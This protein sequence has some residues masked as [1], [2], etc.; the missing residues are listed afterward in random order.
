MAIK[1]HPALRALGLFW[2]KEEADTGP[3]RSFA[4]LNGRAY[5]LIHKDSDKWILWT[6][7][8]EIN[9][10][11]RWYRRENAKLKQSKALFD[12]HEAARDGAEQ[13]AVK[14]LNDIRGMI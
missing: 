3:Y 1:T 14:Y 6:G 13:F 11:Y 12:N 9:Q 7:Y 10:V 4:Q 5:R 2:K 8:D